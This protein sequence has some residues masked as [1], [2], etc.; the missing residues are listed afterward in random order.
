MK[1]EGISNLEYFCIEV[2]GKYVLAVH[3]HVGYTTAYHES[4]IKKNSLW[5]LVSILLTSIT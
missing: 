2:Y 5:E 1:K 4:V 3:V